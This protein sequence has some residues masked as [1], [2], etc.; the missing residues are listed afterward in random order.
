MYGEDSYLDSHMED[1]LSGGGRYDVDEPLWCEQDY[2][3][4][5]EPEGEEPSDAEGDAMDGDHESALRDA[6]F[7]TDEDYGYFGENDD[8]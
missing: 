5:E 7:G 4:P 6:G 3:E 8:F 2:P 1:M